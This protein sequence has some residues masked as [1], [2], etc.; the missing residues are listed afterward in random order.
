MN[1]WGR[2]HLYVIVIYR[3]GIFDP[4]E[5]MTPQLHDIINNYQPEY[6]WTDGDWT[7]SSDYFRSTDFLAWLY[8]ER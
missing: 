5:I 3:Y 8:N 6:L 4:H 1:P 2:G 7:A